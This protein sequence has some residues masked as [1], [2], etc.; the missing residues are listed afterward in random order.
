MQAEYTYYA[1]KNNSAFNANL[2]I[3]KT[4][5]VYYNNRVVI[6]LQSYKRKSPI[7]LGHYAVIAQSVVHRLG[8]AEVTGSSPV[9][10][11]IKSD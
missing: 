10:S 4:Y 3:D 5:I 1:E 7:N 8:K 9:N 11:S 2:V 6:I